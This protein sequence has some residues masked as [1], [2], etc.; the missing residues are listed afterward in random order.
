MLQALREDK[1]MPDRSLLIDSPKFQRYDPSEVRLLCIAAR[2]PTYANDS[3]GFEC[4]L[5]RVDPSLWFTA[6]LTVDFAI[7]QLEVPIALMPNTRW[8]ELLSPAIRELPPQ[9]LAAIMSHLLEPVTLAI[10]DWT[11]T[12]PQIL[13]WPSQLADGIR[14]MISLSVRSYTNEQV[15]VALV[16]VLSPAIVELFAARQQGLRWSDSSAASSL[17]VSSRI[18]LT[19]VDLLL[20]EVR[21]LDVGDVLALDLPRVPTQTL[22]RDCILTTANMR[23]AAG[24]VRSDTFFIASTE[25]QFMDIATDNQFTN[26]Q[27]ATPSV[28]ELTLTCRV[29]IPGGEMRVGELSQL[30]VGSAIPLPV[31]VDSDRIMLLFGQ[32]LAA[33]GR[34]IAI[35]DQLGFEVVETLL[36]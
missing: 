36:R 26:A 28:D 14:S 25:W 15:Y 2:S 17:I 27:E 33:R 1:R 10:A 32:Q 9:L 30:A 18:E 13:R 31:S 34:L 8:I 20:S 16:P 12:T 22:G 7:G 21:T 5:S 3:V 4:R 19:S 11:N 35:G 23:L 24:K 6:A 29:A